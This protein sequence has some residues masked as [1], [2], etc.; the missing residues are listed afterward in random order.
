MANFYR[1]V[2]SALLVL[3]LLVSVLPQQHVQAA[4]GTA[5][6]SGAEESLQADKIA[7]A[8][9]V[10]AM[11]EKLTYTE[12]TEELDVTGGQ[13]KVYWSDGTSQVMDMTR[14]M[15][16]GFD[17]T[18]TGT[19][20]LTVTYD[21][22]STTF[23]VEVVAKTA[24]SISVTRLPDKL[25]YLTTYEE[26]DVTGGEITVTYADG[27][28]AKVI[29][30][31]REM[32]TG[33]DNTQLGPQT[34]TVTYAGAETAYEVEIVS[35]NLVSISC[36]QLPEQTVYLWNVDSINAQGGTIVL[37]FETIEDMAIPMTPEMLS[38]FDNTQEGAQT[39]TVTYQGKTTTFQVTVKKSNTTQFA[40]GLGTKEWPYLILTKEHLNNVR[41]YL[42]SYFTLIEDITFV[43]EDFE[44]GGAYYNNGQGWQPIGTKGKPFT[45]AFNGN[46][47][48][49]IGLVSNFRATSDV[50]VGLIGYLKNGTISDLGIVNSRIAAQPNIGYDRYIGGVVGCA[51]NSTINNCYNTGIV[52]ARSDY[53]CHI[54]GVVGYVNGNST[55]D[56]CFNSGTVI[57]AATSSSNTG[58]V[59]GIAG[60]MESGHISNSYN[61]GSVSFSVSTYG[62]SGSAYAGGI[63]GYAKSGSICNAYNIGAISASVAS[64][65]SGYAGGIVGYSQ[66]GIFSGCYYLNRIGKGLGSGSGDVTACA[67][68]SM[69]DSRTFA[70]FDF[71]SV[72]AMGETEY[73]LPVLRQV[74]HREVSENYTDFSGGNGSIFNPYRITTLQQLNNVR[75]FLTANF[76]LESDLVFS[77]EDFGESGAYYNNGQGWQ[78]IGTKT[79][80]F[81]GFFDGNGH[82]I[83]GLKI[84]IESSTS[85]DVGLFGYVTNAAIMNLGVLDSEIAVICDGANDYVGGIAGRVSGGAITNCYNTGTVSA[86]RYAGGIAGW[87]IPI[88]ISD[89]YNTGL[90]SA[91]DGGQAGGI[92]GEAGSSTISDCYNVGTVS[93]SHSAGGISGSSGTISN[94]Y[95]TGT[96]SVSDDNRNEARAGGIVGY[97]YASNCYNTGAVFAS[98]DFSNVYVGGISGFGY[99]STSNCYNM[100]KV[101]VSGPSYRAYAGGI[102]G[103]GYASDCYNTGEITGTDHAGGIVG[104]VDGG[105]ISNCYNIGGITEAFD[106]G[107]IV[108]YVYEG[109]LS[110]CYNTGEIT[111]AER[112]GGIVGYVYGGTLSNCYNTGEI[113]GT[114]HVGGIV[115][116]VDG[117]TISNISDCYYLDTAEKGIGRGDGDTTACTWEELTRQETFGGF[118]FEFVWTMEGSPEYAYPE[119]IGMATVSPCEGVEHLPILVGEISPTCTEPGY[120]GDVYCIRCG[121]KIEQGQAIEATDHSYGEPVFNW[122]E[123]GKSCTVVFTCENDESHVESLEAEITYKVTTPA[124]CE[125]KGVTTYTATVTFQEEEYTATKEVTDVEATGHSYGKPVFNWSEDGK[126]CTVVFTC[127]NDES[128]VEKLK[129][130]ITAEITTPATC[131]VA[132]ETTYT[133]SVTLENRKY[134]DT[135]TLADIPALAHD[136][137]L[138]NVREAT[139]TQ[140]GYTGDLV[141]AHCGEILEKGQAYELIFRVYHQASGKHHYTADAVERDALVAGGWIY[142]GVAWNAPKEGKPIY[143]VYHP[144]T[145][146]H[147]YTMDA[148]ERDFLAANGWNY[149]GILCYS[150][151]SD[152][153]PLYRVCN[154]YTDRNPHHYT[155]SLEECAFLQSNG[156]RIEGI[157][158][159][160]LS[161]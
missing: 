155:D 136:P 159:Y 10:A 153:V 138:E 65:S 160:G 119:L 70:G 42:D 93:S 78:P 77:E 5:T 59:G 154:P 131:G 145:G 6:V 96:V 87:A 44:Q 157:S 156:W 66:G 141:C 161:K 107:G 33:F 122:S 104:Y 54:G 25:T 108:G 41:L 129:A 76:R 29:P 9:M 139:D 50:Y 109:T 152:G 92:V 13:I 112:A 34:L 31:T 28:P 100:G 142:E 51:E 56:G 103:S 79:S 43:Q 115:G 143:R 4:P 82:T 22:A 20:T 123:D 73:P 98:G 11:P 67:L 30:M 55:I 1:R 15:V 127:E 39:I 126:S 105:T 114:D 95:N 117:G 135:L 26:L 91:H 18:K 84:D 147:L 110:N 57:T 60:Y 35:D 61:I 36:G 101:S 68:E 81:C 53:R 21:Q 86:G 90:I 49:I 32:V 62:T 134:S 19:Q 71:D 75:N 7:V 89:C 158:W 27:T 150:A 94:C 14:E 45:G 58:Y 17:N 120:T 37:H 12:Y 130:D 121:L 38:G 116:Y 149:E 23:Q 83:T 140:D 69:K 3:S 88:V 118:D 125:S 111:A 63:L 40:S 64:T 72:W 97:G 2:C 24:Q 146:N 148:S 47:K 132:G 102:V 137:R 128:H 46:S 85:V 80:P 48:A 52:T 151:D 8:L 144:A 99:A 74:A 133:A 106:A 113:T 16:T 124:T